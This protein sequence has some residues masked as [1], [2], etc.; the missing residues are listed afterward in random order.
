MHAYILATTRVRVFQITAK[1]ALDIFNMRVIYRHL[2]SKA[3]NTLKNTSS[4]NL[5][6]KANFL[7][8]FFYVNF[9]CTYFGRLCAHHQ[10][11]QLYLWMT[12]DMHTRQSSTHNS[13]YQVSHKYSCFSCWWA[14]S[15]PKHVQ[16]W[17]KL[18]KKN[19]AQS[20]LYL[21][22]YTGMHGKQNLKVEYSVIWFR[23]SDRARN[24]LPV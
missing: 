15:R 14:H 12:S 3:D 18:T 24:V 6:N 10:G 17:N 23:Y 1:H 11:K 5:V 19:C 7:K 2:V 21:Q 22:D 20:W 16:K 13:K 4:C 9:F 8:Y